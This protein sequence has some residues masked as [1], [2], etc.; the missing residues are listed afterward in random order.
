MDRE[1]EKTNEISRSEKL[2]I[3]RNRRTFTICLPKQTL[4][5][6]CIAGLLLPLV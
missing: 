2:E 5:R 4:D 3:I 6:L 1:G